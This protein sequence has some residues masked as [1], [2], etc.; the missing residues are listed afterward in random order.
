M[1]IIIAEDDPVTRR[2]IEA[3]LEKWGHETVS[4]DN[5]H[6]AWK[7]LNGDVP[8]QLIILDWIMPGISGIDLCRMIRAEMMDRAIY[9]IFL[10]SRDKREDI[11]AALQAGADDYLSKPFDRDELAARVQ[12]GVRVIELQNSLAERIKQLEDAL[13]QIKQLKGLI[14]ICAYC[15]KIRDD[16]NYWRQL[17]SYI[18]EHSGAEFSHGICPD[19]YENIVKPEIERYSSQN[20]KISA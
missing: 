17:E 11:I 13:H 15:K 3:S 9:I 19:C 7:A 10:T 18:T 16:D 4:C 14:P 6:S 1:R 2:L 5:G 12:V 20:G 8:P